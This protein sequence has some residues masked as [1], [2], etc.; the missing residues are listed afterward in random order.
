VAEEDS[1]LEGIRDAI[2]AAGKGVQASL[3]NDGSGQPHRLVLSAASV[4][5]SA[6]RSPWTPPPKSPP[7][8][9]R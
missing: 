4:P 5:V 7:L 1:S 3:V 2:N 9:R 8:M 6:A